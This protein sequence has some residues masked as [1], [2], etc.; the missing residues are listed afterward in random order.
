MKSFFEN[1]SE[2]YPDCL[3]DESRRVG[4]AVSV[5]F[6]ES[7]EEIVEHLAEARRLTRSVTIQGART[8]ITA[9]AVPD[10]GHILNLGRM[11]RIT[12]LRPAPDANGW[13]LRAQPGVILADLQKALAAKIFDTKGWSEEDVRFQKAFKSGPLQFFT[14]DPTETTA[15]IGGMVSCNASGARSF[16]YGP[17][18]R[19]VQAA[20]IVLADGSVLDLERGKQRCS[21]R[22]FNVVVSG[23]S[24]LSGTLPGYDM[25]RAKNAA[26]YHAADDMD[27]LDLFIGSDGTLGI[28]SEITLRLIPSP[29]AQ[30]G[31][32]AF[33]PTDDGVAGLVDRIRNQPC[34]PAAIEYFDPGALAL[35]RRQKERHAGLS[36]VPDIPPDAASALYV[37]YHGPDEDTVEPCAMFLSDALDGIVTR[38]P[39]LA[40]EPREMKKLKDIRHAIPESVNLLI[41]ERRRSEPA[42]TKLGTDMAV[43][44]RSLDLMLRTYREDL[45]EAGLEYVSFGHIGD[46]HLHVNILPRSLEDYARGREI[47]MNW[48]RKAV[49]LGGSVSAEHGIG[50]LKK[51]LLRV[52][53]GPDGIEEMRKVRRLFD[54]E[55]VLNPGNLF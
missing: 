42:L 33:L 20:R 24:V 54:P 15:S 1:V 30:W 39:W 9:G 13:L 26:G 14:P 5:S 18:R 21:G 7:E 36:E 3:R 52:M 34:R 38:E 47:Y 27:V 32:M 41:D 31:V 6:P 40:S 44:D 37:E 50:K 12:G 46:N 11:N 16:L 35:L 25:P 55:G 2:S 48:A 28:F 19:Y 4:K 49:A 8:G 45:C 22:S 17:T 51:D 23:G 43:P 10:G 53:Y 29:A